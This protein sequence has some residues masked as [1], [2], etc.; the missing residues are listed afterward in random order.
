MVVGPRI[1]VVVDMGLLPVNLM[2]EGTVVIADD[3]FSIWPHPKDTLVPF[4]NHLNLL[5]SNL[6][7]KLN[8]NLFP[9]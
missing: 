8:K 1:E 4:L 7:W 6:Q 5:T 3:T 9:S 2:G